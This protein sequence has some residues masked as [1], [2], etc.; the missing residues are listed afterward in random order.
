MDLLEE[1]RWKVGMGN[2]SINPSVPVQTDS[3]FLRQHQM[4]GPDGLRGL[5]QL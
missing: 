5:F 1:Q 4:V 3:D 2:S